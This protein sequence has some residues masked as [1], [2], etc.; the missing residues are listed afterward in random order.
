[1]NQ[2]LINPNLTTVRAV[3]E[4]YCGLH[5]VPFNASMLDLNLSRHQ[6]VGLRERMFK[7]FGKDVPIDYADT[8]LS[9]TDKLLEE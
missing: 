5:A 8:I 7:V 6:L 2:A 3:L 1:M 9:I 4:K